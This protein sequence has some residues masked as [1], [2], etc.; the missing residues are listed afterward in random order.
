MRRG[1][2][3]NRL[4]PMRATASIPPAL[5]V[6]NTRPIIDARSLRCTYRARI[7]VSESEGRIHDDDSYLHGILGREHRQQR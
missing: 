7:V 4:P 5:Y 2:S 1:G 6:L 3:S